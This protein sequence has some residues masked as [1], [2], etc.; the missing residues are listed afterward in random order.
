LCNDPATQREVLSIFDEL[1]HY[2]IEIYMDDLTPYGCDFHIQGSDTGRPKQ[3]FHHQ[4]GPYPI[5]AKGCQELL[6]TSG[7]L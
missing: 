2:S 5:E 7:V 3:N 1:V 6:E 4:K